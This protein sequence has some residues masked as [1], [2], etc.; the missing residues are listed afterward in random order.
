MS[1]ARLDCV[2]KPPQQGS[3]RLVAVDKTDQRGD[4]AVPKNSLGLFAATITTW[5]CGR[6]HKAKPIL[7]LS[8][9]VSAFLQFPIF[10]HNI[11]AM[12][13]MAV[14]LGPTRNTSKSTDDHRNDDHDNCK[15][16]VTHKLC[17]LRRK[18]MHPA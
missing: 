4:A 18:N 8:F 6:R 1:S 5:S 14:S 3:E 7:E 12:A 16:I 17:S 11:M 13:L 9:Y 2:V 15:S 10:D